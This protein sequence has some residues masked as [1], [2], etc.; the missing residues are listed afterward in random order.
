MVYFN[1]SKLVDI[2]CTT[3]CTFSA[4]PLVR[5]LFSYLKN[6]IHKRFSIFQEI[7]QSFRETQTKTYNQNFTRKL[8]ITGTSLN[9]Q[10]C[11]FLIDKSC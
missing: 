11:I 6:K 3:D 10:F 4:A 8:R 1:S 5:N 9:L 2:N 7:N